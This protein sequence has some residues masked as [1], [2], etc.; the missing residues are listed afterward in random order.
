MFIIM[1]LSYIVGMIFIYLFTSWQI[2][3]GIFLISVSQIVFTLAV[4]V[5]VMK[6]SKKMKMDKK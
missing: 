6:I 4:A 5:R 2:A 3:L 1:V